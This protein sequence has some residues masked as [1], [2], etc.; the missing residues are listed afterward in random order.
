MSTAESN[1]ALVRRIFHEGT[2]VPNP[3]AVVAE[4]FAEDFICHGPPGVN[5]AHAGG[6]IGPEHCMLM[7][8]FKDVEFKVEELE[9]EE[10]R[11]KCRFVASVLQ[12][13][14]YQGRKPSGGTT[15]LTGITTFVVEDN[16][17]K[18]GWGVLS[19]S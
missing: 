5:H 2:S 14:E 15:T 11:V 4:I 17:V 16:K 8:A 1:K 19:W 7:D 18:E 6:K 9:A 13:A 10:G 3:P 12:I